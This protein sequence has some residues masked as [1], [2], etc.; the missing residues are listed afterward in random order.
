MSYILDTNV[1]SELI[2]KQP[3]QKVIDWLKGIDTNN[4]FLSIITIGEIR[5]GIEKLP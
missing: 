4:L 5:K 2:A 1:I 3:N